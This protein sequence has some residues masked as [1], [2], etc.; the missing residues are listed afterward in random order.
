MKLKFLPLFVLGLALSACNTPTVTP[1]E[2]PT[3]DPT[4]T[5]TKDPTEESVFDENNIIIHAPLFSD[6]HC[7]RTSPINSS[8]QTTNG[9]KKFVNLVGRDEFDIWLSAGDRSLTGTIAADEEWYNAYK[10]GCEDSVDKLFFCHGNHDVYWTGCASRAEHY[11]Y[12]NTLGLFDEDEKD[13]RPNAG[14]R[15]KVVNGVD[16]LTIDITTYDGKTNP[17]SAGTKEWADYVLSTLDK[18]KPV[19][20][21]AHATA[22]NTILGSNDYEAYGVWGSSKDLYELVKKYPNVILFTGHTHYDCHSE[23]NIWQ[24]DFTAINVPTVSGGMVIDTY[25]NGLQT[26]EYEF[27]GTNIVYKNSGWIESFP[28]TE[29]PKYSSSQCMYVEIDKNY[30][31]RVTRYDLKNNVQIGRPWVIE[32]PKD[33][34]SHLL[35]YNLENR[36][37]TDEAP[38]ERG[39]ATYS[40]DANGKITVNFDSFYHKDMVYAYELQVFLDIPKEDLEDRD[41]PDERY[42]FM[43]E[44]YKTYPVPSSHTYTFRR[45]YSD[46][47]V[48]RIVGIDSLGK[49]G[50]VYPTQV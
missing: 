30:N 39:S 16:F 1:T 24:G 15:H 6:E 8:E 47:Y 5:P 23:K 44:Y 36:L 20:V 3:E 19:I 38:E 49:Y 42:V 43:E 14:N 18:T 13:S 40:I 22:K 12:F 46:N 27:E 21:L 17:I 34:N 32:A 35:K 11:N 7:E 29:D 25:Y 31:T 37:L 48:V 4:V 50:I 26:P 33:D 28:E 45:T 41:E 2:D 9:I 10:N